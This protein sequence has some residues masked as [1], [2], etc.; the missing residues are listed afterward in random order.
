MQQAFAWTQKA[1]DQGDT[2]AQY[3]LG[4][5]YYNGDGV[6]QNF[7]QALAW[8]QEAA[9]HGLAGA[10]FNLGLM[11]NKGEGVPEDGILG[12]AW[13]NLAATAGNESAKMLRELLEK[14]LSSAELD[15]AQQ[16]SSAWKQGQ[17]I[18]RH[19]ARPPAAK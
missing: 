7:Q 9:T 8:Y 2:E 16:L 1:A 15:E 19:G 11:Y 18:Q 5:M 6:A 12:Y 14:L 3:N 17:L 4:V 10:Q 13:I